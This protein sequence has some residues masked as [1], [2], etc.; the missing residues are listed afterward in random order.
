MT[1]DQVTQI[2]KNIDVSRFPLNGHH[3]HLAA[4]DNAVYSAL[5]KHGDHDPNDPTFPGGFCP[6]YAG[7][8]VKLSFETATTGSVIMAVEAVIVKTLQHEL[9]EHLLHE[10]QIVFNAHPEI[11]GYMETRTAELRA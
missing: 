11:P 4:G 7:Q 9:H 10:G 3:I 2:L 5:I 6:A 1:K 8:T